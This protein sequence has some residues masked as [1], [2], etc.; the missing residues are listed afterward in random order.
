MFDDI[1][2]RFD[3]IHQCEGERDRQLATPADSL[4]IAS[5]S[6]NE[7]GDYCAPQRVCQFNHLYNIT[8]ASGQLSHHG[9]GCTAAKT[10]SRAA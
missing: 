5:R 8:A 3:T 4:C 1:F 9:D 10:A 2:I 6:V 7:N